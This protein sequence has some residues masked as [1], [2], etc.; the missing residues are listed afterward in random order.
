MTNI[1]IKGGSL[2][3]DMNTGRTPCE[4]WGKDQGDAFTEQG[5]ARIASKPPEAKREA[6]NRGPLRAL[7]RNQPC[8]HPDF[9]LLA[10]EL[11]DNQFL[12]L[13]HPVCDTCYGGLNKQIS[14]H[15]EADGLWM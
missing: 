1:F 4:D 13:T 14:G 15:Q 2:D 10:L 7:R 9:G 6:R 5:M 8:Q 12:L 11:W 3:I